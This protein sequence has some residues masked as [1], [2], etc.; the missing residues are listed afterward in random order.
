ML[1]EAME[2]YM[3]ASAEAANEYTG[4]HAPMVFM[5]SGGGYHDGN[6]S[7]WWYH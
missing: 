1:A 3:L 4:E 5:A 2:E 6:A 7:C